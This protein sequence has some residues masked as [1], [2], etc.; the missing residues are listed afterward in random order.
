[1]TDVRIEDAP[2]GYD[3]EGMIASHAGFGGWVECE[4]PARWRMKT[5]SGDPR[6]ANEYYCDSHLKDEMSSRRLVSRQ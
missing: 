1:M 3:C 5:L 2:D 4:C 6:F